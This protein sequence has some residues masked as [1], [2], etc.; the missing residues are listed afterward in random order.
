MKPLPPRNQTPLGEIRFK[1]EPV[2]KS[3]RTWRLEAD[4]LVL[5]RSWENPAFKRTPS[6]P[7][8]AR[9]AEGVVQPSSEKAEAKSKSRRPA[10][11]QVVVGGS[12]PESEESMPSPNWALMTVKQ[13]AKRFPIFSEGA[14]RYLIFHAATNGF[15]SVVKRVPGQRKVLLDEVALLEWIQSGRPARN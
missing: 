5:I 14:L 8:L 15:A 3:V 11:K 9:A 13:A 7:D 12:S 6:P 1:K 4:R 10:K 2:L